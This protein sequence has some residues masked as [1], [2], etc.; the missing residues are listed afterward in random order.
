[1]TSLRG[2]FVDRLMAVAVVPVVSV[3]AVLLFGGTANAV[4]S[5]SALGPLT[6]SPSPTPGVT[7]TTTT[8]KVTPSHAVDD[9]PVI[10]LT[11]VAPLAAVGAVQF[12]MD[13]TTPLAAPVPVTPE[14]FALLINSL[15]EGT[16]SL[17]AVFT[18]TSPAAYGPSDVTTSV[19][20]G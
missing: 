9:V 16:H 2:R 1:M 3:A 20:D 6:S 8:L 5:A 4:P 7:D 17:T 11:N 19:A 12:I 18:P 13:G 14:G 15:P 10:F